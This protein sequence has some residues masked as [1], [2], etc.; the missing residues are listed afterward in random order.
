MNKDIQQSIY[1]S[2]GERPPVDFQTLRRK[3]ARKLNIEESEVANEVRQMIYEDLI[4]K[5]ENE[6]LNDQTKIHFTSKVNYKFALRRHYK[7]FII[8][9]FF[10][11]P[12]GFLG[13]IIAIISLLIALLNKY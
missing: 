10:K 9:Q 13:L 12:I 1:N 4:I 3:I 8:E 5:P 7:Q 2:F 6:D 11:E